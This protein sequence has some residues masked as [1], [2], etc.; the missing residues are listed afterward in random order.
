MSVFK[1]EIGDQQVGFGSHGFLFF[2]MAEQE[3][4][5][6]RRE[7]FLDVVKL[8]VQLP[9]PMAG[10]AIL[11]AYRDFSGTALIQ[12]VEV[13]AWLATPTGKLWGFGACI[14]AV[15]AGASDER[16]KGLFATMTDAHWKKLD[17]FLADCLNPDRK[18][19]EGILAVMR[20]FLAQPLAATQEIAAWSERFKAALAN[21]DD[22]RIAGPS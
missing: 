8:L 5:R 9:Q 15:E 12:E 2:H 18:K 20:E 3:Y 16:I 1:L 14:K 4:R 7:L 6:I 17:G 10:E 21:F 11:L 22:P 13:Q 19:Q